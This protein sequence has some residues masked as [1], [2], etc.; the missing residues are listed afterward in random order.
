MSE[1][2][3]VSLFL[4]Q[5]YPGVQPADVEEVLKKGVELLVI[6]R[7]MSEALQVQQTTTNPPSLSD[8]RS[9]VSNLPGPEYIIAKY[10]VIC[11]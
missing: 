5:H 10:M 11:E 6:G 7:G 4:L 8:Q 1:L 2:T 3:G 9:S